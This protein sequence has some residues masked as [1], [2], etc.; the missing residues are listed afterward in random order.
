MKRRREE[1][2]GWWKSEGGGKIESRQ[3]LCDSTWCRESQKL[4]FWEFP[5]NLGVS[6]PSG[7]TQLNFKMI[8]RR[9]LTTLVRSITLRDANHSPLPI[10]YIF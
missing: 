2:S 10:L 9:R 7:K 8:C 5:S 6:S 1:G 3:T 4:L